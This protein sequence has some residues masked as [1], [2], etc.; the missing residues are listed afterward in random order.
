MGLDWTALGVVWGRWE[1]VGWDWVRWGVVGWGVVERG[2]MVWLVDA[3]KEER[4][5][6]ATHPATCNTQPL[7]CYCSMAVGRNLLVP[8]HLAQLSGSPIPPTL[9]G[10]GS[11]AQEKSGFS[12]K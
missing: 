8:S 7:H 9:G 12:C 4:A 5:Q 11:R 3:P 2:G 10:G 6:L 1:R